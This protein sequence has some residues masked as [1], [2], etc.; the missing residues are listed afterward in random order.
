MPITFK[1]PGCGQ[2]CA[3]KPR[4]AS[5][6]ARCLQCGQRFVIP[7]EDGGRAVKLKEERGR[8]EAGFY[9]SVFIYNWNIFLKPENLPGLILAAAAVSFQ[10]F[11][12]GANYSF[13]LPGFAVNI[14]LDWVAI[15]LCW[16]ILFWYYFETIQTLVM[17]VETLPTVDI[18]GFFE[19][20]WKVI[21]SIYL[22]ICAAALSFLPFVLIS[23]ILEKMN[24]VVSWISYLIVAGGVIMFPITLLTLA[25]S[26]HLWN[27]LRYD[28]LIRPILKAP[29][30]YLTV[31]VMTAVSMGGSYA[32]LTYTMKA[33]PRGLEAAGYCAAFFGFQVMTLISMRSAGLFYHYYR[34]WF[35]W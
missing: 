1:C 5:H 20:V 15:M 9:K 21:K 4:Y 18:D 8:P 22:F 7:A 33:N 25:G 17:G 6:K 26:E 12:A 3:F 31:V 34:C 23:A 2:F 10:F 27:V 11:L 19:Y 24:I 14:P 28:Y 29:F 35:D 32:L 30:A 16:G 13:E